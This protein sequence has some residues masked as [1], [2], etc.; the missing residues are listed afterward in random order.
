MAELILTIEIPDSK[1]QRSKERFLAINPNTKMIEGTEDPA[2]T[3]KEWI[4]L[5][6]K[7]YL[8]KIDEQGRNEIA[9]LA[10]VDL[11]DMFVE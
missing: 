4:E 1:V 5:T 2:Y 8:K 10:I 11:T 9:R 7:K 6:I 3:D